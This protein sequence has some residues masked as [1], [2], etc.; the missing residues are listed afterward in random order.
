MKFS[1]INNKYQEDANKRYNVEKY[2]LSSFTIYDS[3]FKKIRLGRKKDG[4]YVIDI[5]PKGY[6]LFLSGGIGKDVS[7]EKN[8]NYLYPN[9]IGYLYDHTIE[10]LPQK[11]E[12]M[13]FLKKKIGKR[14]WCKLLQNHKNVFIKIDIEKGEYEW[15]N[16][17]TKGELSSIKQLVM[18][19][20][21]PIRKKFPDE[22][23]LPAAIKL[24]KKLA[25]TH[26][27]VHVHPNNSRN[28]RVRVSLVNGILLPHLLELTYIRKD[29]LDKF[30]KPNK[31]RL[32]LKKLDF[33]NNL[34]EKDLDINFPP[35]VNS[36]NILRKFLS[37]SRR[38][39]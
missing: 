20:H 11:I 14:T 30:P 17:L 9:I 21:W 25:E 31:K 28:K 34:Y 8:F 27:L 6:D 33:K 3:K 13:E 24:T 15:V 38:R 12:G 26:Y 23:Y 2:D 16:S 1:D 19:L 36:N 4:G 39:I 10:K 18:E 29:C 5:L 37:F 22:N 32:P 35:F 7:F